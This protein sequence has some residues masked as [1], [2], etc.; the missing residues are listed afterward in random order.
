MIANQ[1]G[2][3]TNWTHDATII[4]NHPRSVKRYSSTEI[5]LCSLRESPCILRGLRVPFSNPQSL[6]SNQL[7][8][9]PVQYIDQSNHRVLHLKL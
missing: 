9:P 8:R 6:I 4:A 7:Q 1:T 5:S 3:K 2:I